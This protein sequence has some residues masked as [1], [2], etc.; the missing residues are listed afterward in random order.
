MKKIVVIP[1]QLNS[2][3][4]PHKVYERYI[5]AINIKCDMVVNVQR[6]EPLIGAIKWPF[7]LMIA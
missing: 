7:K 1:A 5:Q 2:P 4:L 3:I 6:Y